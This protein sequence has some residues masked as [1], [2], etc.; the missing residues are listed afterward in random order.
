MVADGPG[1]WDL[2]VTVETA[3]VDTQ[4]GRRDEDLR[5]ARFLNTEAFPQMTYRGRGLAAEP[6][7]H[8]TMFGELT[9]R[10]V[11]RE[12]PLT[13]RFMG[14]V[15]NRS[16]GSRAAFDATARMKRR[17]FELTAELEEESGGLVVGH[18][19][20]IEISAELVQRP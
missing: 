19:V 10:G 11:S 9:V 12:V 6:G 8:W 14:L 13:G 15:P 20:T 7:G 17:D 2:S 16:G 4:N 3:S 18:D 1:D 5:S